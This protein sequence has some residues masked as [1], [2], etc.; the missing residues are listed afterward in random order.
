MNPSLLNV[1]HYPTNYNI[2]MRVSKCININFNGIRQIFV[3][4]NRTFW[5]HLHSIFKVC[6]K[7]VVAIDNLHSP[8][9]QYIGG[10]DNNWVSNVCCNGKSISFALGNSSF[11]LFNL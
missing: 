8:A 11:R 6:H 2:T 5:V 10:P 1:L 4:K 9:T 3:D 7:L